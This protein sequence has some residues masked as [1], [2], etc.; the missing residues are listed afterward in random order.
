MCLA[1]YLWIRI[2][3]LILYFSSPFIFDL[4]STTHNPQ[5]PV[6]ETLLQCL[7]AHCPLERHLFYY[8][9]TTSSFIIGNEV[10]NF[11]LL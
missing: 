6:T 9:I 2:L 11:T 10:K 7:F 8:E 1:S 5:D 4:V 3:L